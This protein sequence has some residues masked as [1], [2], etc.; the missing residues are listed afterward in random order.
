MAKYLRCF[1]MSNRVS[2]L[3]TFDNH[4]ACL[5]KTENGVAYP[6]SVKSSYT[7]DI[8]QFDLD[9]DTDIVIFSPGRSITVIT[10]IG[11]LVLQI[12]CSFGPESRPPSMRR[13]GPR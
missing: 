3:E 2:L 8:F 5:S 11:F 4:A 9:L 1:D 10:L 6:N 7:L 12:D 13:G